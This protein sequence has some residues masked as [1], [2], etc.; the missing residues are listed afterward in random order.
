L[1]GRFRLGKSAMACGASNRLGSRLRKRQRLLLFLFYSWIVIVTLRLADIMIFSQE[2]I[3]KDLAKTQNV[4]L[5]K[6]ALR[7][8]IYSQNGKRLAWSESDF[9]LKWLIPKDLVQ[10]KIELEKFYN[11]L[12]V[13]LLEIE[14]GQK[15]IYYPLS[16]ENL[17]A[18]L[19]LVKQFN[20][21]SIKEHHNRL[22][23]EQ[24]SWL[25]RVEN[26]QGV[27]GVEKRYNAVLAGQDGIYNYTKRRN[28]INYQTWSQKQKMKPGQDIIVD[29]NGNRVMK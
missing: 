16:E 2:K 17:S 14:E 7:G 23:A 6:P 18:A 10:R 13:H 5:I 8:T 20:S 29:E 24:P 15:V 19:K 12:E 28:K 1:L 21:F 4:E 3:L 22:T 26:G 9:R 27:S 25:G 11:L